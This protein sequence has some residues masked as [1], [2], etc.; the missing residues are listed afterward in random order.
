MLLMEMF[1]RWLLPRK[2]TAKAP[3]QW[4]FESYF[5]LKWSLFRRHL[6]IFWG[7]RCFFPQF[8]GMFWYFQTLPNLFWDIFV[9]FL[10]SMFCW[11]KRQPFVGFEAFDRW[12]MFLF[13]DVFDPLAV[14]D[15]PLEIEVVFREILV[16][17]QPG[18]TNWNEQTFLSKYHLPFCYLFIDT[19][20]TSWDTRCHCLIDTF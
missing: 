19:S 6:C 17:D 4:W 7:G 14:E 10:Q 3:E 9:I 8:W 16:L 13:Q 1:L 5:P 20:G 2:L 11:R 18:K 15:L 12:Y